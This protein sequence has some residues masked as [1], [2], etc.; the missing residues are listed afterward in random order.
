MKRV[1]IALSA[2]T[3]LAIGTIAQAHTT[4]IGFVPGVNPGEV[5]FYTGS[6]SHG[7]T[8]VNEGSLT[9]TGVSLSF[10][11]TTVAFDIAPVGTKPSGLVDGTNNFFWGIS[12]T[13]GFSYDF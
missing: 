4:S 7:G 3:M 13:P 1:V 2:L 12:S 5:T 8:P 10:G 6:Y 11:P 9:L